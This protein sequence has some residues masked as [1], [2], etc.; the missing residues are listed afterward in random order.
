MWLAAAP[1]WRL[2][3]HDVIFGHDTPGGRL[4][5]VILIVSILASVV[6]VMLEHMGHGGSAAAPLAK[7]IIEAYVELPARAPVVSVAGASGDGQMKE[8]EA[9]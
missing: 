6:A 8:P 4:F 3:L 7:R 1:R 9:L 5:D 2:V